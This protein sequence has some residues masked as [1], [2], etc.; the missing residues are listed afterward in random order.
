MDDR[1]REQRSKTMAAVKSENTKFEQSFLNQLPLKSFRGI[2]RYPKDVIGKPDLAQRRGRTAVFIDSCFWHGCKKH[3]RMPSSNKAYWIQKISRNRARDLR[4]T[5]ELR[6]S[7]WLVMRVWEHSIKS[8]RSKKWWQTRIVNQLT[9]RAQS[10]KISG[11]R[12]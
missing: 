7:G 6:Q 4:V 2:E 10:R 1:T 3:L 11:A 9:L 8:S 12:S 5:K